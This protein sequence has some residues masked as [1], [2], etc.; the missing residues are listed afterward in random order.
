MLPPLLAFGWL[1]LPML[2]WLAAAAAPVL[3]HLWSRR[4][5]RAMPWAAMEYLLAANRRQQTRRRLEQWLMLAVRTLLVVLVV[6]AVAGPYM[7]AARPAAAGGGAVHR[8][9][10]LDGSYSMGC[11]GPDAT[12]FERAKRIARQIVNAGRQG[13]AFSLVLMADRPRV[14]IGGAAVEP[15]A[16]IREIDNLELTAGR[17]R[18]AGGRL[19]GPAAGRRRGGAKSAASGPRSLLPQRL[20]AGDLGAGA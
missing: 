2:G 6:V 10:V 18:S 11:R 4:Q 14:I 15:A 12:R 5:Y 7:E 3:I 17:R 19:G 16:V 8:V 13:D 9:L 20:A 1:S